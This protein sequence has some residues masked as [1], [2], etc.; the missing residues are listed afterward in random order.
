MDSRCSFPVWTGTRTTSN[1]LVVS[2]TLRLLGAR[3]VAA[4]AEGE[5]VAVALGCGAGAKAFENDV[6]DALRLT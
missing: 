3:D 6:G 1:S 5:I 2:E 4:E